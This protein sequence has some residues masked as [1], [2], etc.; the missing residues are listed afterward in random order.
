MTLDKS[1]IDEGCDIIAM[2]GDVAGDKGPFV[3]PDVYR[4]FVLPVVQ[5]HIRL[6][7]NKERNRKTIRKIY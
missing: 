6:I 1:L 4:E 3:S 7:Q 2:G 5:E